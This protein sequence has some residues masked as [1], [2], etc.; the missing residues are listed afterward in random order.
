MKR[1]IMISIVKPKEIEI[2]NQ[3]EGIDIITLESDIFNGGTVPELEKIALA[4]MESGIPVYVNLKI[5][6]NSYIISEKDYKRLPHILEIIKAL[7]IEGIKWSGLKEDG[8]IDTVALE[9]IINNK[10]ELK[11]IFG[12]AIDSAR[13]YDEALD[14]LENYIDDIEYIATSGGAETAIDGAYNIKKAA[15]RFPNKVLAGSRI[16]VDSIE[17][18]LEETNAAGVHMYKYLTSYNKELN[19]TCIDINLIKKLLLKLQK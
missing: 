5:N 4:S 19:E 13:N 9:W 2:I 17:Q 3:T 12:R 15:N 10:N 8:T 1:I 6:P 14:I 11:L 16:S 18:I 7:N